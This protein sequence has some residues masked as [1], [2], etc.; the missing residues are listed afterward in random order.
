MQWDP[1][2]EQLAILPAGN[3]FV[4]LWSAATKE[5]Q[6]IDTEFK[7]GWLISHVHSCWQGVPGLLDWGLV[8]LPTAGGGAGCWEQ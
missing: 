5:I 1:V 4:L 2:T 8:Q 6:R 3:T 7:V